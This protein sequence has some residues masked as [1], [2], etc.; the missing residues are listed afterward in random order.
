MIALACGSALLQHHCATSQPRPREPSFR[1]QFL[2][3][4]SPRD[5]H[6][7]SVPDVG[8]WVGK[9]ATPNFLGAVPVLSCGSLSLGFVASRPGFPRDETLS[10]HD[11]EV[12]AHYFSTAYAHQHSGVRPDQLSDVRTHPLSAANPDKLLALIDDPR[13][14]LE[15]RV[16]THNLSSA[17]SSVHSSHSSANSLSGDPSLCLVCGTAPCKSCLVCDQDFCV[18]HLYLCTDCDNRYCGSC[19]DEHRADGHWSD[20][21][22]AAEL[23]HT[24]SRCSEQASCRYHA[25]AISPSARN[26]STALRSW[27]A[28]LTWFTS[29]LASTVRSACRCLS[30]CLVTALGKSVP[31]SILLLEVCL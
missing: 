3:P 10:R 14:D 25:S 26:Q 4:H 17:N 30:R 6:L 23:N 19:L 11:S 31:Q 2:P 5:K 22:T 28:T 21:D 13:L 18:N 8:V 24:Q 29:L 16:F 20:S 7:F 15:S 27:P 9:F 12:P 1:R